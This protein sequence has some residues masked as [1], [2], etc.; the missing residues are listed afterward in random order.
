MTST[1]LYSPSLADL[2]PEGLDEMTGLRNSEFRPTKDTKL[3]QLDVS[4][5]VGVPPPPPKT[6]PPKKNRRSR[7]ASN[8]ANASNSQNAF[9]ESNV[10]LPA[11][12]SRVL[13]VNQTQTAVGFPDSVGK[14]DVQ[15]TP[16]DTKK[17]LSIAEERRRAALAMYHSEDLVLDNEETVM[18]EALLR[19]TT[20]TKENKP[21]VKP[22]RVESSSMSIRSKDLVSLT[23]EV[24][25]H[26]SNQTHSAF[27][28]TRSIL[29]FPSEDAS[30]RFGMSN[31]ENEESSNERIEKPERRS[32][33]AAVLEKSQKHGEKK[34][35]KGEKQKRGLFGRLFRG[36]GK[37]KNSKEK[38]NSRNGTP[39]A[40]ANSK[41][42]PVSGDRNS[43]SS[44]LKSS[45]KPAAPKTPSSIP[46]IGSSMDSAGL[47]IAG[48]RSQAPMPPSPSNDVQPGL[49]PAS[50]AMTTSDD[51][52]FSAL[53]TPKMLDPPDE[54]FQ[55]GPPTNPANESSLGVRTDQVDGD[56]KHIESVRSRIAEMYEEN[57]N[58]EIPARNGGPI[59]GLPN[60]LS[61]ERPEIFFSQDEVSILTGPSF[62][63]LQKRST[64]S[65]DPAPSSDG[66]NS[67]PLGHYSES[68]DSR[69]NTFDGL[70]PDPEQGHTE[71]PIPSDAKSEAPSTQS[72]LLVDVPG[73]HSLDPVGESPL[74]EGQMVASRFPDPLGDS[75]MAWAR[76]SNLTMTKDPIGDS[77]VHSAHQATLH[78]PSGNTLQ[79]NHVSVLSQGGQQSNLAPTPTHNQL[80]PDVRDWSGE[81]P[82][83]DLT[84][85]YISDDS[86]SSGVEE[87]KDDDEFD[88]FAKKAQRT[89]PFMGDFVP[90]EEMVSKGGKSKATQAALTTVK[91]PVVDK[92][93]SGP[94]TMRS[95]QERKGP[96]A[97][98]ASLSV[99]TKQN[100]DKVISDSQSLPKKDKKRTEHT[101][102]DKEMKISGFRSAANTPSSS[103]KALTVSGAAFS[104]AK[105]VAYLHRLSGQPSP[106]HSWLKSHKKSNASSKGSKSG[107][108][109]KSSQEHDGSSKHDSAEH[110][111]P[112]LKPP[113]PEDVAISR[114]TSSFEKA[115]GKS[116]G[117]VRKPSA[118][119]GSLLSSYGSKF[120]GRT[121]S[122]KTSQPNASNPKKEVRPP[123]PIPKIQTSRRLESK[124]VLAPSPRTALK[125]KL[126][127]VVASG[128]ISSL[129]VSRGIMLRK[130]K[131]NDDIESGRS[132]R[133]ILT[134]VKKPTGGNRFNFFPADESEIKDPIQRA[135]RRLLSKAAIP[136]QCA[137]RRF[138]AK[139]EA[140]D[141]MWAL[142]EVQSYFRRWRCETNLQASIHSASLIQAHFRGW[143]A[144][145]KVKDMQYC[146][147]QI[148]K[149]V[150]G[151]LASVHAYDAI[152]CV[153]RIQA[154]VR[155]HSERK[156]HALRK[157][158]AVFLQAVY[159]G[160]MAR[161]EA[162]ARLSSISMIQTTW[163]SYSER[164]K[165]QF[166]IVDIIIAQS[167][168]RRW[169]ACRRVNH[170]KNVKL[171]RFAT[172]VQKVWRGYSARESLMQNL[173]ACRIQA[174]WRGFQSYTDYIFALVDILVV[175]RTVRQFLAK[176]KVLAKRKDAAALK[177]QSQWRRRRAQMSMLYTLVHIIIAQ[178][179]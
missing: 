176:R 21:K 53:K 140:V 106:R 87:K 10:L 84:A 65:F 142:I 2:N 86:S 55:V 80:M 58:R 143:L 91:S 56:H 112:R 89:K 97:A 95:S 103:E 167:V 48:S 1:T 25:E 129:A 8:L 138:L 158:T 144:R 20:T 130:D 61:D 50:L 134:P 64:R 15:P 152:Y 54:N 169:L 173:A 141:R 154:L 6:P 149:V 155:G 34:G 136:I 163:R 14:T 159:R 31:A 73:S 78:D 117:K 160:H 93:K 41:S 77:P 132:A 43:S 3:T 36:K 124:P 164:I 33:V 7:S 57:T 42:S 121:L 125:Q 115:S 38:A 151:Y 13:G 59:S 76:K 165:F 118:A 133:V 52:F 99:E 104:N 137:A 16:R 63:S 170:I 49:P 82:P 116:H 24:T 30:S 67:D 123:A 12:V 9:D 166:Q 26:H 109:T 153:A 62:E 126:N 145:D 79:W 29:S 40:S 111:S 98:R 17:T 102:D 177:I 27:S 100:S 120:H 161:Q 74:H 156:A 4:M 28:E 90:E 72:S 60:S 114:K 131:R 113:T 46:P 22:A 162:N 147:V 81:D 96:D 135:G 75:P 51:S 45:N 179:S 148:Q 172:K 85:G 171:S 47:K 128:T 139:R 18:A 168:V 70:D 150:R 157:E 108:K 107:P 94:S 174:A 66:T 32:R 71:A 11:T 146:A 37:D 110:I 127:A 175:Q 178:V 19:S 105:A 83:L 5:L 68:G 69:G 122:K 92:A 88:D 23:S 44:S 119:P 101:E 39:T 35:K